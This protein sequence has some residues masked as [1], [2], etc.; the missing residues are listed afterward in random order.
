MI[1]HLKRF[2]SAVAITRDE[3]YTCDEAFRFF[4]ELAE[5]AARGEDL[6]EYLPEVVHHLK[7]CPECREDFEA[8]LRSLEGVSKEDLPGA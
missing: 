2:L 4:D 6:D 7:Q 5:A 3:E 1:E 8:L